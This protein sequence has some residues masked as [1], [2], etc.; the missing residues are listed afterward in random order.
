MNEKIAVLEDEKDIIELITL[1]LEKSGYRV[2]GF[3]NANDLFK[4]LERN[5][6]DLLLLDLILP[7]MD[8]IDV[9]R[10]IKN[11]PRLSPLQR[12]PTGL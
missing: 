2:T 9:C 8:G 5:S 1:H 6:F 7:D 11:N 12:L 4:S 10:S 3:S